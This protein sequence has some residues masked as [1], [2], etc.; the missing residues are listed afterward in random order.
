MKSIL[1]WSIV[2]SWIC[3]TVVSAITGNMRVCI[4]WAASIVLTL[5]AIGY[6]L[7]TAKADGTNEMDD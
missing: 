2:L 4:V 5:A 7:S 3:P 1:K 6:T